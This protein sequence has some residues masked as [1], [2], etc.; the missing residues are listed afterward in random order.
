MK[1]GE[2]EQ[3]PPQKKSQRGENLEMW[4]HAGMGGGRVIWGGEGG[5]N[6]GGQG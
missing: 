1:R 5:P 6:F 2:K 3:T 4:I